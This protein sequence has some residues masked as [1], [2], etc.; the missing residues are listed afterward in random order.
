MGANDGMLHAFNALTGAE[1]FAYVPG[2][3]NYSDLA[4][5][6][7]P[8]Y[9]HK[10]FVD[11]PVVVSTKKQTPSKNYLVGALGRGGKGVFGLDVT[12]P[13]NFRTNDVLWERSSDTDMG[14]VLGEPLVVTLNNGTKAVLVSNGVNS[15]SKTAALFILNITTGAVIKEIKTNVGDAS[16]ENGLFAPRGWDNDG[17][18]TVDEVYAGDLRGNLW[19][20]D[21]NG[22]TASSWGL[23]LGGS[24]LFQTKSGQPI[25][26]GLGLARDPITGKRWIFVG[27]GSFLT[28]A[29]VT[30]NTVQSMYGIIDDGTSTAVQ[31][32]DLTKRNIVVATTLS[33]KLVRGFEGNSTL[34]NT[35]K[36]WYIDLDNPTAGERIVSNPRVKG[37][38]LLTASI[39][40]PTTNTCDAGGTGYINALDAFSGTSLSSPFF[41]VNGDGKV[42][43]NDKVSANGEPV[44][45]GSIDL[46]VG[47]PT[48]PTV[49]DKLL[50]VG[51][52]KGSLGSALVNPQGGSNQ[53]TSWHEILRD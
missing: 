12:T 47:M 34:D 13:T 21:L 44:P 35:K 10:Y 5:L 26:A 19:K 6:S 1:R 48:L 40:P 8:Q 17:N 32:S 24:P 2:G 11:G 23:A 43:D 46:G 53:R 27:T 4:S 38:V 22:A 30:N 3:I 7:D 15:S 39:I 49:I 52:S 16:N 41:D 51:G 9:S 20:F 28:A 42:D 25:T 37:S 18:G 14:Q 45:V 29:D 31:I 36:G 33:G 50:V